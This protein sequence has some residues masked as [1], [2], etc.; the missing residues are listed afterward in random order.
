MCPSFWGCQ[1]KTALVIC[2][3]GIGVVGSIYAVF[4]GLKA[5]AVS[6]SINAIGLLT[7]GF[8]IPVFGLM[9]IGDGSVF[10]GLDNLMSTN[11]E[12]FDST[13]ER[14]QEV[15]FATIFT[16]MMLVQLFYWGT[17]QQIIQRALAAKNLAEGQKGL[18]LAS[19]LKILGPLIL[20]LPGMIAYHYF[21][22]G[23]ASSDLAY[24]ELVRAVLPD[25]L[26][27]F[28]CRSAFRSYSEFIQQCA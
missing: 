12:R 22:G 26:V 16:G 5:V 4:G 24:P 14:G 8:L 11:P 25:Y 27:G 20:V 10:D 15:P 18:L 13:G 2:I 19:F 7:G 6:D 9:A 1:I 28:F 17:N 3:W 21:E 23:L